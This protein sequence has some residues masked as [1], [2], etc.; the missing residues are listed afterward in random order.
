[1]EDKDLE[2]QVDIEETAPDSEAQEALNS[3][4]NGADEKI[5]TNE[6]KDPKSLARALRRDKNRKDD[7]VVDKT[8]RPKN[9]KKE[10][11]DISKL[12]LETRKKLKV[13]I[14]IAGA[15]LL[16]LLVIK[17][18]VSFVNNSGQPQTSGLL[19]LTDMTGYTEEDAMNKIRDIGFVNIKKEYIYDQFTQDNCVIKTNHHINSE[20]KPNEEIV[21]YICDK[22]LLQVETEEEPSDSQET[23]K[24]YFTL[25]GIN[26]VDMAIKDNAFYAI[27]KNNHSYAIKNIGCR[28]GYQDAGGSDIGENKYSLNQDFMALPG[29]K[30]QIS[31]EIRNTDAYYIYISGL[32]FE[33]AP[34]PESE[35]N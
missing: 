33:V 26:I 20:L 34:V 30:F 9:K 22:S 15:V 5:P 25:D 27:L 23:E 7:E 16:I 1:M 19:L 3:N 28:I 11:F 29:E 21:V 14:I 6:Q 35:R 12:P 31:M 17:P 24:T 18:L 32:T 13:G 4:E 2:N 8:S 10:V